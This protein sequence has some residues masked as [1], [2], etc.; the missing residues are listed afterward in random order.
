MIAWKR[1]ALLGIASWAIPF[2]IS[3][4]VFPLKKSDPQLFQTLMALVEIV[5]AGV[6][7]PRYFRGR[8]ISSAE[9]VPVGLLWFAINLV[10]DYPMFAYGPMKMA[11]GAYYSEIGLIYLTF[12]AFGFWASRL[13]QR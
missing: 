5:T 7:F 3:F 13:A 6:L 11:V 2:A 8:A 1:A 9:A 10:L 12:P 4:L